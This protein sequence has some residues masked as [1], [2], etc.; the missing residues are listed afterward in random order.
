MRYP[1]FSNWISYKH[2]DEEN[3]LVYHHLLEESY[4]V[5]TSH[6]KFAK[7]LNGKRNP[8]DA[9]PKLNRLECIR[10]IHILEDE[11][12]IRNDKVIDRDTFS[13][14]R[15]VK[16]LKT[17]KNN[18]LYK[19]LNLLLMLSFLPVFII[20]ILSAVGVI[21][22]PRVCGITYEHWTMYI[23][24]ISWLIYP[25]LGLILVVS[26]GI[27]E[28]CH[29]ISGRAYGAKVMEYGVMIRVLPAFYTMLDTKQVKSRLKQIQITAAG[30]EGQ[31]LLCGIIFIAMQMFPDFEFIG[32][33]IV[34]LNMIMICINCLPIEGIDGY[35][36]TK[37]AV[38]NE[39][40]C[41]QGKALL[42]NFRLLK[43]NWNAGVYGKAKVGSAL[44]ANVGVV[45]YPI[46]LIANVISWFGG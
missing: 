40:I 24:V 28:W 19:W 39:N 25:F 23:D 9:F 3:C 38:G 26:A 34:L 18:M 29:A 17:P 42:L 5:E 33:E 31:M 10:L 45:I 13:Y 20:G 41:S 14:M 36:I 35:E 43:R 7:R 30:L 21:Y 4:L 27:H 37:I 2:I 32:F 6:I 1:F 44:L 46:L 15:T 16:L 22:I 11:G 12:L 8:R